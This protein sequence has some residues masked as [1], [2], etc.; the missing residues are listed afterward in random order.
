MTET[1][2]NRYATDPDCWFYFTVRPM[3]GRGPIEWAD[4]FRLVAGHLGGTLTMIEGGTVN[5]EKDVPV[6]RL[7]LPF[8]RHSEAETW[9]RLH[10]EV[11]GLILPGYMRRNR[12][13]GEMV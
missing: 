8:N 3:P 4:M 1:P 7:A 2:K 5:G 9:L 10:P 12:A 11:V 6:C 13:K